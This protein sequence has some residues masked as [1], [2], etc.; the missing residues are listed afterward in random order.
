MKCPCMVCAADMHSLE[1]QSATC[2]EGGVFLSWCLHGP[3]YLNGFQYDSSMSLWGLFL[4]SLSYPK[5]AL[6]IQIQSRGCL[7]IRGGSTCGINAIRSCSSMNVGPKV[8]F[9]A[10]GAGIVAAFF[11]VEASKHAA[12]MHI[13]GFFG[14]A[15]SSVY[16]CRVH[17]FPI[18]NSVFGG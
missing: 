5:R 3:S 15:A 7:S 12:T 16:S 13:V 6:S 8:L 2:C 17:S 10:V 18:F 1:F 9:H 14:V 4:R 11:G